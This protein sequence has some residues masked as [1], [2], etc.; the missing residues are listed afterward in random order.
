M[1]TRIFSMILA[2]AMLFG[3]IPVLAE[4]NT[5]TLVHFTTETSGAVQGSVE[6]KDGSIIL[7]TNGVDA[8]GAQDSY[9]AYLTE[10]AVSVKENTA[11][12]LIIQA[13]V[14][15]PQ[16]EV[17]ENTT[18]GIVLR[19]NK[20][21]EGVNAMLRVTSGGG[22]RLT[23]RP[24]AGER[25]NY[26]M[27]PDVDF[28]VTLRM[29]YEK[30]KITAFYLKKDQWLK[31]GSVDVNLGTQVFGGVGAF[32][33]DVNSEITASYANFKFGLDDGSFNTLPQENIPNTFG[34][35]TKATYSGGGTAV[36]DEASES[37][38][39]Y[40]I[41]T[42]ALNA[43]GMEDNMSAILRKETASFKLGNKNKVI[44]Q[45]Q[46]DSLTA[47]SEKNDV[48]GNASAGII[49]RAE[50]QADAANVMLR[51]L[52]EGGIR[53]TYR[54]VK[55]SK[56]SYQAIE[57][58]AFP[59]TLRLTRQGNKICGFYKAQKGWIPAG[60]VDLD[61]GNTMLTGFG[62]FS[63]RSDNGVVAQISNVVYKSYS[64]YIP[65]DDDEDTPTIDTGDEYLLT[66]DFSDMD[67]QNKSKG[68]DNPTWIECEDKPIFE[69]DDAGTVWLCK[70][71]VN[72]TAY[73]GDTKWTDYTVNVDFKMT[74]A[75]DNN[76]FEMI[77]RARPSSVTKLRGAYYYSFSA[78]KSSWAVRKCESW[79]INN[80]STVI[81]QGKL[82][83]NYN[84]GAVHHLKIEVL[85]NTM[86]VFIDDAL[87]C[88]YTDENVFKNL[89][90]CI[91]IK[92]AGENVK[93]ANLSVI[94]LKDEL[95]GDYDN[96]LQGYFDQP[97]QKWYSDAVTNLGE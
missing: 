49:F 55:G 11:K 36:S 26:E 62:A 41:S 91:G 63:N 20:T 38:G 40:T 57:S 96:F 33:A 97:I 95:G 39:S 89:W 14:S 43:W 72:K 80:R 52:P 71:G 4:E 50:N 19:S 45:A 34:E 93:I 37:N 48:D 8:W 12:K 31:I 68:V 67:L 65:E 35:W 18:T 66:E 7:K 9:S 5:M 86:N 27:G 23:Y 44:L 2:A 75:S 46:F 32:S 15:E 82:Q 58:P 77:V 88:N 64:G 47:Q 83:T 70:S 3:C 42:N 53:F 84:D 85:D 24:I 76:I 78:G 13:T 30:Q 61:L 25:T 79:M 1:K 6:E 94:K 17:L 54:D 74:G 29:E 22:I 21:A 87:I 81:K 51:V 69:T 90:G 56:T 60:E 10:N 92:T 73:V 59:I 16:G 28:P